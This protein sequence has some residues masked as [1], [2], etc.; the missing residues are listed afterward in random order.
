MQAAAPLGIRRLEPLDRTADFPRGGGDVAARL[1]D[2]RPLQRPLH[3]G[4]TG[5]R[6]HERHD[7]GRH[8]DQPEG[9]EQDH[10]LQWPGCGASPRLSRRG[11]V[12]EPI[13]R[14]G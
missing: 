5:Q 4:F 2:G 7:Q 11:R 13:P 9:R 10:S 1:T 6:R 3:D 12:R 14:I 8:D